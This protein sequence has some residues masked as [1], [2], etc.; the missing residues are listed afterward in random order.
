MSDT[1]IDG[2]EVVKVH[3]FIAEGLN[4]FDAIPTAAG[5]GDAPEFPIKYFCQGFSRKA[6]T[7]KQQVVFH[8]VIHSIFTS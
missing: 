4:V 7:Q 5:A 1:V 3:G 8:A 2:V 6:E